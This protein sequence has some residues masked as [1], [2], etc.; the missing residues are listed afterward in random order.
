M[1]RGVIAG[2]CRLFQGANDPL[3]DTLLFEIN[4]VIGA[5]IASRAGIFDVTEDHIVCHARLG[6][7]NDLH[8]IRGKAGGIS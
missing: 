5:Q 3:G 7:F 1:I 6:K 8:Q 4:Q 2:R